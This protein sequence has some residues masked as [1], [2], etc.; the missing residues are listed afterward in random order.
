MRLVATAELPAAPDRTWDVVTDWDRQADWMPDVAWMKVVS[1]DRE[2]GARVEV[3]TKVLGLPLTTDVLTVTVWEPPR[4]LVVEHRGVV[5]GWGEWLFEPIGAGRTR[6]TWKEEIRM[7][8][9][10]LGEVAL[11]LYGPIQR[12]ML[13]RSLRGLQR[14][15]ARTG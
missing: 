11:R 2:L 14:L 9:P 1:A 10:V 15:L 8:P 6:F 4:R 7:S 13:R 12:W 5:R 3:R